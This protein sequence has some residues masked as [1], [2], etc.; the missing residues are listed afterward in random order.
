[1]TTMTRDP[2]VVAQTYLATWNESDSARRRA[3]LEQAWAV[4]ATYLDPL[5]KGEGREGI[6]RT[7]ETARERFPGHRF[8]LRGLPD[9]PNALVRF[10]WSLSSD[11]GTIVGDGTDVVRPEGEL[12]I[13]GAGLP[14]RGTGMSAPFIGIADGHRLFVR[15]WGEGPPVVLLAPWAMDSRLWAD[16]MTKLNAGDLRTV[17]YDRR[18]H[19]RSTDPGRIDHDLLADD[20]A[21]VLD[22]LDLTGVTLVA[23]SSA[24]SEAIRYATRHGTCRIARLVLVA[25]M[26]PRMLAGEDSPNGVP[27]EG[28]EAV[29]DQQAHD[30]PGWIDANAE[31]FAPGASRRMQD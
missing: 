6:A 24:A 14:R 9:G 29:L 11:S 3:L 27:R 31:P 17:A 25:P 30:L 10:A 8:V 7:I 1:M 22:G 12:R 20:L 26:G 15:D 18:G 5:M 16:V 21:A 23:H 19:G 4:D 28:I 13:A 2:L